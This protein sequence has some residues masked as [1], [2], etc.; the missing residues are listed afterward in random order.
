MW[1]RSFVPQGLGTGKEQGYINH[2]TDK[3]IGIFDFNMHKQEC[4]ASTQSSVVRISASSYMLFIAYCLVQHENCF[5]AMF[6]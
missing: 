1:E 4:K 2:E 3:H 6:E 5:D